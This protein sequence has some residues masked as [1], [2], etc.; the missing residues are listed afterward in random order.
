[1][2]CYFRLVPEGLELMECYPNL[3]TWWSQIDARPSLRVTRP[4]PR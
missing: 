4:T 2:F 3:S 1:M